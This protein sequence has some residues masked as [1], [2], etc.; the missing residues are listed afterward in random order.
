MK[1][2][3]NILKEKRAK[4]KLTGGKM[5]MEK[6]S[7]PKETRFRLLYCLE[8]L[9]TKVDGNSKKKYSNIPL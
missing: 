4:S 1:T 2:E 7:I 5:R 9:K 3:N 8:I 6:N